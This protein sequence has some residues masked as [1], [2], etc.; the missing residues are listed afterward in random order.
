MF[1]SRIYLHIQN[2]KTM[3]NTTFYFHVIE[4]SGYDNIAS[5]GYYATLEE[6]QKEVNRLQS[7]FEDCFFYVFQSTSKREPEFTTC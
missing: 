6:A 2:Q 7:Y 3:K 1:K 4:D 5:R